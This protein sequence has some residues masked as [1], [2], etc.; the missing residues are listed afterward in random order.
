[1]EKDKL[2]KSWKKL[3]LMF[4]LLVRPQKRISSILFCLSQTS[5]ESKFTWL[6][7]KLKI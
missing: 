6:L 2:Q 7:P 5:R 1:M 4:T 3:K